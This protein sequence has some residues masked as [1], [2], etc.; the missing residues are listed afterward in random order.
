MSAPSDA[1][2]TAA[3]GGAAATAAAQPTTVC[4]GPP[5]KLL[6]RFLRAGPGRVA[7]ALF[8]VRL[9][10]WENVPA[11]GA[12]LACNHVSNGD[13]ILLWCGAPRHVH[14]MSKAELW[15][16]AVL[17]W[18]MSRLWSFPVRR[19][20]AD[21][22]ALAMAD[23]LLREGDLVGVFPEG[24]RHREGMGEAQR[25]TAF[26]AVRSGALVVPVGIAG[27]E[28]IRPPGS[29]F[30]H[31]PKVTM[32]FGEPLDP[33]QFDDRRRKERVEAMT[34]AIMRSIAEQVVQA[35]AAEQDR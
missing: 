34:E 4:E 28:G 1:D 22:E 14:F 20:Q 30:M 18:G 16:N 10:G 15:S 25:G 3:D 26:M 7:L 24:T 23:R 35:R 2:T 27:T 6:G 19:G 13:P 17:R 29:V 32:S 11:G 12:I 33:A 21:R 8:R 5:S 9:F 31:F